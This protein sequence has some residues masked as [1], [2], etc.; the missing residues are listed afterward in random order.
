L[1]DGAGP[2]PS[3]HRALP[4]RAARR[5]PFTRAVPSTRPAARSVRAARSDRG[6]VLV[7]F[8]GMFPLILLM[9]AVALQC[10]VIGYGFHLAG[11]AADEAARAGAAA[12]GGEGACGEAARAHI[13]DSWSMSV[14]CPLQGEVRQARVELRVPVLFPGAFNLPITISGTAGAVEEGP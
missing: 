5:A 9:L 2:A 3:G 11:N 4:A 6:A 13:P 7:E 8:A 12:G 14:S 1:R 10:A